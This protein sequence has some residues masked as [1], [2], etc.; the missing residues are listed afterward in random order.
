MIA[1][2]LVATARDVDPVATA[3][4]LGAGLIV[5]TPGLVPTK[6]VADSIALMDLH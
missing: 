1:A 6:T 3:E 4:R 5:Q 2:A